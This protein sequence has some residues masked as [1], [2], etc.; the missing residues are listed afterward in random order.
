MLTKE[1]QRDELRLS[2]KRAQYYNNLK[3]YKY[4]AYLRTD[5]NRYPGTITITKEDAEILLESPCYYCSSFT[6]IGL[7]RRDSSKGHSK[8]NVVSCCEKCN[9]ILGDL[10]YTAKEVLRDKLYVINKRG[11]L[12]DWEIPI[13]RKYKRKYEHY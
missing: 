9:F 3:D 7:D 10:P 12:E 6:N 2:K 4:L 11:F 13:K 8:E 1:E 5:R